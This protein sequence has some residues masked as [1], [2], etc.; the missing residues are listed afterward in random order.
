MLNN[1]DN[2]NVPVFT[3]LNMSVCH[4][5]S[6]RKLFAKFY[7]PEPSA[8][9]DRAKSSCSVKNVRVHTLEIY[10][11]PDVLVNVYLVEISTWYSSNLVQCTIQYFFLLVVSYA[12]KK[13]TPKLERETW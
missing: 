2:S 10:N 12:E 6:Y 1:R 3:S 7:C 4:K 9:H 13:R 11:I 5:I 8:V